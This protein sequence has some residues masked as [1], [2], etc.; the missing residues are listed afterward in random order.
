MKIFTYNYYRQLLTELYENYEF[1]FFDELD[2]HK[3]SKFIILRHDIDFDID[4]TLKIANIEKEHSVKSTYFFLLNSEFYNIHHFSNINKLQKILEMGH[5]ISIHFDV[6]NYPDI[7]NEEI[8]AYVDK[9]IGYFKDLFNVDVKIIS[10]HRPDDNVLMNKINLG[11]DHTYMNKYA[12]SIRY[13]SDSKKKM[14]EGDFIK[15]AKSS[16]Y[17]QIQL[18][19]HPIWWN[20]TLTDAQSDYQNFIRRKMNNIKAEISANSKIFKLN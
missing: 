7:G 12:Q 17:N 13:L 8:S 2:A 14:K 15:I 4:K 6:N 20:E 19:L 9:E 3:K 1:I 5:R 11:I 16:K 10:F 18:L